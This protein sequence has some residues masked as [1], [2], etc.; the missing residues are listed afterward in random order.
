MNA[1]NSFEKDF[2]KLMNNA[3]FGKTM[4]SVRKRK[5]CKLVAKYE[6]KNGVRNL[7]CSPYC[8]KFTVIGDNLMV[9]ELNQSELKFDKPIIV[10]ATVLELSK[11]PMFDFHY[12][13]MKKWFNN[14]SLMYSDTDSL[15]Y[16]IIRTDTVNEKNIYERIK[17]SI[18]V[19]DTSDYPENNVYKIP[20]ANK[21]VLGCFKDESNGQII[22]HFCCLKAKMYSFKTE[23]SDVV[24]KA[25]GVVKS[26]LK[27]ISFEDYVNTLFDEEGGALYSDMY[28]IQSK[29]FKLYTIKQIKKTLSSEDD[30]RVVLEN[31]INTLALGHK[32]IVT[33]L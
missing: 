11:Y 23:A 2:F 12:G 21:K 4:E 3:M 15:V 16:H 8:K 26:C 30:K 17:E 32:D 22:T 29:K 18:D 31:K 19:F 5:K 13:C 7:I 24:K 6:G 14:I 1:R 10:G 9:I 33:H 27:K 25:K 20:S 28:R